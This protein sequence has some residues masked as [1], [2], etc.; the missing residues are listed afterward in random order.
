MVEQVVP[1]TPFRQG[2][3]KVVEYL[4]PSSPFFRHYAAR[5]LSLSEILHVNPEALEE[6]VDFARALRSFRDITGWQNVQIE[7]KA[8]LGKKKHNTS[9]VSHVIKG[10]GGRKIRSK[11]KDGKE[12]SQVMIRSYYEDTRYPPTTPRVLL[13][14]SSRVDTPI[15]NLGNSQNQEVNEIRDGGRLALLF[16]NTNTGDLV[17]RGFN[18]ERA[19]GLDSVEKR[20]REAK[21]YLKARGSNADKLDYINGILSDRYDFL[22]G[23]GLH[24][25]KK[26]HELRIPE[27][28]ELILFR[29]G[30]VLRR[31]DVELCFGSKLWSRL[32]Q[33]CPP[34][35]LTPLYLVMPP[36]EA[37]VDAADRKLVKH[38]RRIYTP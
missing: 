13:N 11:G 3:Q 37:E 17:L 2:I 28:D 38:M 1:I 7:F 18:E 27:D 23:K 19:F 25:K 36:N 30:D 29:Q 35:G 12:T 21:N 8:G 20:V 33:I 34:L 9:F 6:P 16:Y 4:S 22:T 14:L 24:E 5:N 26:K 32:R 10:S 15:T 31:N